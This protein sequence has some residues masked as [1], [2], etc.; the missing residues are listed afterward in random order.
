M[1]KK[2]VVT[3]EQR[4]ALEQAGVDTSART[5]KQLIKL[6]NDLIPIKKITVSKPQSY[7]AARIK[8]KAASGKGIIGGSL[9]IITDI[10]SRQK[11]IEADLYTVEDLPEGF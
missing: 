11:E 5:A 4:I 2:Y 10:R 6:Y 7:L 9:G 3:V 8:A 1:K